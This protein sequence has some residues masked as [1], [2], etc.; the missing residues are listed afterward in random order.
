MNFPDLTTL[1]STEFTNRSAL[2]D[3]PGI[4]FAMKGDEVLYIGKAVSLINRW[5]SETHHRY[6]QL[7]EIEGVRLAWLIT[8]DPDL[9]EGIEQACIEHFRPVLNN[10]KMMPNNG[11]IARTIYIPERLRDWINA[12][13]KRRN[14][15]SNTIVLMALWSM[16]GEP[17]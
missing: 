6:S 14:V 16:K 2:P 17:L 8:D 5:K 9:L 7:A 10:S 12:E 15:N 11:K 3:L 4:Y 13:A 1:P